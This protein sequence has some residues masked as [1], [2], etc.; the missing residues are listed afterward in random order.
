MSLHKHF[1]HYRLLVWKAAI[2]WCS[3]NCWCTSS[4]VLSTVIAAFIN[5]LAWKW[6]KLVHLIIDK[7]MIRSPTTW[8]NAN[9]HPITCDERGRSV[10]RRNTVRYADQGA[11]TDKNITKINPVQRLVASIVRSATKKCWRNFM[12]RYQ[13]NLDLL[14]SLRSE[15]M[16]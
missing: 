13:S 2:A 9:V 10:T 15:N 4:F 12:K 14:V 3:F 6:I 5:G 16:R 7:C 11:D 1:E 8:P